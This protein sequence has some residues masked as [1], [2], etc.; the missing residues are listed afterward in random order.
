MFY[1][2]NI[3]VGFIARSNLS[4]NNVKTE[5]EIQREREKKRSYLLSTY[6]WINRWMLVVGT[7]Y[8]HVLVKKKNGRINLTYFDKE[9]LNI[10]M[11]ARKVVLI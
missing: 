9:T 11:N 4:E 1:F 5:W 8:V 10:V 2:G 6:W 3:G 7:Y